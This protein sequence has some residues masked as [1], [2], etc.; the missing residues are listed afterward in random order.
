MSQS[1]PI[2]NSIMP[3]T[4][5]TP[6]T[7]NPAIASPPTT[8]EVVPAAKPYAPKPIA[9]SIAVSNS[10]APSICQLFS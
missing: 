1:K 6:G 7:A 10:I 3:P 5:V 8:R 9:V 4:T 2:L